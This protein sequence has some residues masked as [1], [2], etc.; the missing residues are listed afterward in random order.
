MNANEFIR[1]AIAEVDM[2]KA[3]P[4]EHTDAKILTKIDEAV[5]EAKKLHDSGTNTSDMETPREIVLG[6]V[7][8]EMGTAIS[9]F[10]L[11]ALAGKIGPAV[12]VLSMPSVEKLVYALRTADSGRRVLERM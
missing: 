10:L 6:A 11:D 5:A 4:S 8:N 1:Q 9:M 7:I 12:S 3:P 2:Q